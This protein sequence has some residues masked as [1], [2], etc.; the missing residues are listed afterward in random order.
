MSDIKKKDIKQVAEG[1]VKKDTALDKVTKVFFSAD[2]K[3]VIEY[4]ID[5][6]IIPGFKD[7]AVNVFEMWLFGE[8]RSRRIGG[9]HVSYER[10][11]DRDRRSRN[12]DR[13]DR[14]LRSDRYDFSAIELDSRGEAESVIF[15]MSELLDRYDGEATVADL[16]SLV[17][18]TSN[19]I[20]NKWGWKD[21]R[22]FNYARSG[23]K[24]V[25]DF[26]PPVYLDQTCR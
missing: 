12:N 11:Y 26:A 4:A 9:S 25:L 21:S 5:E 19:H 17:G 16:K 24:Y 23:R 15:A 22:D 18:I 13:V 6:Y 8:R 7:T 2:L 10:M 1:H 14:N 3:T 20:D